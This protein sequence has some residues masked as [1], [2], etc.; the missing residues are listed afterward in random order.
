DPRSASCFLLTPIL[1]GCVVAPLRDLAVWLLTPFDGLHLDAVAYAIGLALGVVVLSPPLLVWCSEIVARKG[2]A[3]P[4]ALRRRP[5]RAALTE[6]PAPASVAAVMCILLTLRQDPNQPRG[7]QL[8][9]APLLLV[10]W[11]G[12]RQGRHGAT[13]TAGFGTAASLVVLSLQGL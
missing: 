12:I 8:W 10:V 3:P 2:I 13:L 1:V 5:R 4:A 11:A 9:G 6:L 7:W